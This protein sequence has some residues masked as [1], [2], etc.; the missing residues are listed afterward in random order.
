[1]LRDCEFCAVKKEAVAVVSEREGKATRAGEEGGQEA[2]SC[3]PTAVGD[4]T[5]SVAVARIE[6][7]SKS[8]AMY[9]LNAFA[10]RRLRL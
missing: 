6:S 8:Y 7:K 10:R 5:V 2:A 4:A 3:S 1:M 9:Y